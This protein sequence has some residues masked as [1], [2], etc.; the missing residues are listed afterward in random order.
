MSSLGVW[1]FTGLEFGV[2]TFKPFCNQ[3]W[4]GYVF[5]GT[6]LQ[7]ILFCLG[8]REFREHGLWFRPP[9]LIYG[10]TKVAWRAALIDDSAACS[11]IRKPP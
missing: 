1:V 8:L 3:V 4:H 11:T 9:G 2:V 6:P 10:R 5:G 7:D